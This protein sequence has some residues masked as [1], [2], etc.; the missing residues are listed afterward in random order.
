MYPILFQLG[1]VTIYSYGFFLALAYLAATYILWRE[2]KKQGFQEEKLIDLSIAKTK[3]IVVVRVKKNIESLTILV[4]KTKIIPCKK[5][6]S[7]PTRSDFVSDLIFA[8]KSKLKAIEITKHSRI[9]INVVCSPKPLSASPPTKKPT[10][11]VTWSDNEN[12]LLAEINCLSST[13]AGIA[14]PSAGTKKAVT[15]AKI[16]TITNSKYVWSKKRIKIEIA[17]AR[18][19]LVITMT[20]LRF[21]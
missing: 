2:G 12:K 4:L 11:K 7:K 3:K 20:F 9:K 8:G 13:K 15:T 5:L 21:S 17:K 10:T 1:P 16:I 6:F 18:V 14:E 19:I